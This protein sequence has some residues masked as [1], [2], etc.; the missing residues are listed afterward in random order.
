VLMRIFIAVSSAAIAL[1]ACGA[2]TPRTAPGRSQIPGELLPDEQIQQV[3]NRLT[4]GARPG[5]A[6]KIRAAGIESWIDQQLHP[7]RIDDAKTT[8]TVAPYSLPHTLTSN[9]RC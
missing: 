9:T 5:D 1:S 2:Q 7:D 3:L 4:L 8:Q 6:E